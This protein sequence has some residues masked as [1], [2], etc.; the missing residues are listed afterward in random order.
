MKI[1][2]V[3]GLCIKSKEVGT[4]A[5]VFVNICTTDAIPA[6]KN[7]S[8]AELQEYIDSDDGNGFK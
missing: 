2:F 7:I 3:A 1:C 4:D 5:K 6:P 8:E